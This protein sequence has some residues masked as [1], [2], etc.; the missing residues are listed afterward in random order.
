MD[1]SPRTDKK[2]RAPEVDVTQI[3][4]PERNKNRNSAELIVGNTNVNIN[5]NQRLSSPPDVVIIKD[6]G[7]R[8]SAKVEKAEV[9]KKESDASKKGMKFGIRVLPPNIPD[10]GTVIPSKTSHYNAMKPGTENGNIVAEIRSI[11]EVDKN[12]ANNVNLNVSVGSDVEGQKTKVTAPV[13]AKRREKPLAPVP[14]ARILPPNNVASPGHIE[15]KMDT[16]I[17]DVKTMEYENLAFNRSD[18]LNSSG[19]KR[20]AQ[21]IP[22]EIPQHMM[23]AAMFARS[24][25]KPSAESQA[26]SQKPEV[27]PKRELTKIEIKNE[28]EAAA[29]KAAAASK[30][31]KGKA[32]SP[33]DAS[34]SENSSDTESSNATQDTVVSV[35]IKTP[36]T[37]LNFTDNF[38][39]HNLSD[40]QTFIDGERNLSA[41]MHESNR[42]DDM[43][44]G[45]INT[46]TPK[47]DKVVKRMRPDIPTQKP[48]DLSQSDSRDDIETYELKPYQ[49]KE[50]NDSMNNFFEDSK[51]I[52]SSNLDGHSIISLS[53]DSFASNTISEL[54]KIANASTMIELNSS[55]I[56]IHSSPTN[57]SDNPMGDMDDNE[58]KAASLGDLSRLEPADKS[59]KPSQGTLERAQSLDISSEDAKITANEKHAPPK[60]RKSNS[61]FDGSYYEDN[62]DDAPLDS[63][64]NVNKSLGH[65]KEPR[66]SLNISNISMEG[67][68]TFQRNR[69]KKASEWGNLEDAILLK[70]DLTGSTNSGSSEMATSAENLNQTDA[71][72]K[73]LIAKALDDENAKLNSEISKLRQVSST[74][75]GEAIEKATIKTNELNDNL[76]IHTQALDNE[77][78]TQKEVSKISP[79]IAVTTTTTIEKITVAKPEV[80]IRTKQ[81]HVESYDARP[82]FEIGTYISDSSNKYKTDNTTVGSSRLSPKLEDKLTMIYDTNI[83]DDIKVSRHTL[84]SSLERPK[85][86]LMKKLLAQNPALS[87]GID[88]SGNDSQT[89]VEKNEQI[90]S[91]AST[92]EG[93]YAEHLNETLDP[94]ASNAT[95]FTLLNQPDIVNLRIKQN[96]GQ[97]LAES[98]D[99]SK[100]ETDFISNINIIGATSK[101]EASKINFHFD[102][103]Y[104]ATSPE[105]A[106]ARSFFST[107]DN[108]VTISTDGSQPSSIITIEA[109]PNLQ[110]VVENFRNSIEVNSTLDDSKDDTM[111][112]KDQSETEQTLYNEIIT[113]LQRGNM[114]IS[115]ELPVISSGS[116]TYLVEGGERHTVGMS[117]YVIDTQTINLPGQKTV[118]VS[119]TEDEHGNKII[120]QNVEETVTRMVTVTSAPI[121]VEQYTF[122][123]IKNPTAADIQR[124]EDSDFSENLDA[125]IMSEIQHQNPNIKFISSE[126]SYTNTDTMTINANMSEEETQA[127][128]EK[129]QSN[130]RVFMGPGAGDSQ[131]IIIKETKTIVDESRRE[132]DGHPVIKMTQASYKFREEDDSANEP[133]KHYKMIE[134]H[135][136]VRLEDAEELNQ[137]LAN[138]AVHK[139][140]D[141]INRSNGEPTRMSDN[142]FMKSE[143]VARDSHVDR[144]VVSRME[145]KSNDTPVKDYI[146]EIE[147][148][149]PRTEKLSKQKS[150]MSRPIEQTSETVTTYYSQPTRFNEI[151][152]SFMGDFLNNER[153]FSEKEKLDSD[154]YERRKSY[155]PDNTVQ[156]GRDGASRMQSNEKRHSD[157]DLP[158]NTHIKFRTATYEPQTTTPNRL[159]S[160]EK[161]L[162]QIEILKSNFEKG[163]SES[164]TSPTHGKPVV[165]TKPSS[166]PVKLP[167]K[168]TSPHK[169]SAVS[170]SKIPVLHSQSTKSVSQ[171]NLSD[172]GLS[173]HKTSPHSKL[174]TPTGNITITS[175][176]SSSR[177]PSGK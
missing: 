169:N 126:P 170:P 37:H 153:R 10:D 17:P 163:S 48:V 41:S 25:R 87:A 32:P 127:F 139:M 44:L 73:S 162:S 131:G 97:V 165:S 96:G 158:R 23:E 117:P 146:T 59:R 68:N 140:V 22:Q 6:G 15:I 121:E 115:E 30:K 51:S 142:I 78:T 94:K 24:N 159:T 102:S 31:S 56:T 133:I 36:R 177:N 40:M 167:D 77:M 119:V 95:S 168:P 72:G 13:V 84:V 122:G 144:P 69:L 109:D 28:K 20:D 66:L 54:D 52:I 42:S 148:Q 99:P 5:A 65:S 154:K 132:F 18:D 129:F 45:K 3:S 33:P 172:K 34:R 136:N 29:I 82:N 76:R 75:V 11:D 166:I 161:R 123:I 137:Q 107:N 49:K 7:D 62:S 108:I 19:I 104:P 61:V 38:N 14:N 2:G 151:D 157:F 53:Q 50:P 81:M 124:I 74:V 101:N 35:D 100:A 8:Y 1:V 138:E 47:V 143:H 141:K 9:Q 39:D 63:S 150:D 55:D 173:I 80:Q 57:D 120:T 112:K 103:S 105:K 92:G 114:E 134:S 164:L 64:D 118:T 149:T 156:I 145:I 93:N 16:S 155:S 90:S 130:P 27:P 135:S 86:D 12:F 147:V 46:S 125:K 88:K 21:G 111:T 58:R 83:P 175:I 26:M 152:I 4:K 43:I 171:E 128:L 91:G 174:V 106:P 160:S 113:E 70:K 89:D 85:S 110:N 116:S 71:T 67:L 98:E 60:K 176:K 79:D